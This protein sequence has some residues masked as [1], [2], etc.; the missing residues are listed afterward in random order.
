MIPNPWWLLAIE[1][2]GQGCSYALTYTCIVAYASVIAPP[3]TT[4][5]VQVIVVGMDDGVG[6]DGWLFAI[7]LWR[8]TMFSNYFH[9]CSNNWYHSYKKK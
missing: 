2:F 3:G 8:T 1:I 5:I 7:K 9:C 4:A 6:F